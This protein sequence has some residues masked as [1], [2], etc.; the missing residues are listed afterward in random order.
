MKYS[1]TG[2]TSGIGKALFE[3]LPNS[4][5][6]SRSNGYDINNNHDRRRIIEESNNC[7]VFINNACNAFG[8]TL[9]LLDLFHSWKDTNKTIINIGSIIAEDESVLK[10]HENLLEYQIQK[11]S[12]RVLHNDLVR[13][14]TALTLKYVYFGYVGTDRILK[15][16]PNMTSD[17]YITV[18][19]AVKKILI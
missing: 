6:F 8:Q 12:L 1:I 9:L 19:S 17:M 10:N 13:L 18:D 14:D 16:Y 15:K 2:H 11:K 5:G 3:T 4:K 7:D